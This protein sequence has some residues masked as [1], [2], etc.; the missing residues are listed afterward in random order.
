M[1]FNDGTQAAFVFLVATACFVLYFI[2]AKGRRGIEMKL[3]K[4]PAIAAIEEAVGAATEM[5]RPVHYTTD[6]VGLAHSQASQCIAGLSVLGYTAQIAA[7][8]DCDLIVTVKPPEVVAVADDILTQAYLKAGKPEKYQREYTLRF[9][10]G[11]TFAFAAGVM[12]TL[13]REKC[14]ANIFIGGLMA[15]SLMYAE[16]GNRIGAINIAGTAWTHQMPFLVI[17]CDYAL[18]GEEIY[19]AGAYASKDPIQLSSIVGQDVAKLA[20]IALIAISTILVTF[21]ITA[22]NDLLVL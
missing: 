19:A 20:A 3:R 9:L 4:L 17:A 12:G 13:E 2:I 1:V 10:S 16:T 8:R 22:L 6:W 18:I 7:E 5:G 14:G 11:E 21:G 15:G